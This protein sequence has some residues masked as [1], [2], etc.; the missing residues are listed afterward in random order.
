MRRLTI[1]LEVEAPDNLIT[2]YHLSVD[3]VGW[4]DMRPKGYDRRHLPI[5]KQ[6]VTEEGVDPKALKPG[7]RIRWKPEHIRGQV[8][9]VQDQACAGMTP[10]VE[11]MVRENMAP[12]APLDEF[13]TAYAKDD[14]LWWR[15]GCGHHQN[16]F[17]ALQERY[18]HALD[19]LA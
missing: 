5:V 17:D 13:L 3:V 14:N 6:M 18:S 4:V 1:Q 8:R 7:D 15:I 12:T 10:A 9:S 19:C 16:L 11:A 2:D